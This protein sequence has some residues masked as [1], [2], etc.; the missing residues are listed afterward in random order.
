MAKINSVGHSF[1]D[2]F[3]EML[4]SA[5]K[6]PKGLPSITYPEWDYKK[7]VL[8]KDHCRLYFPKRKDVIEKKIGPVWKDSLR[9]KYFGEISKWEKK[10]AAIVNTENWINRQWS[11]V[12]LDIESYINFRG[13]VNR[14]NFKEMPLYLNQKRA[15]LDT[16]CLLLFDQSF[17]T[18]SWV[19]NKRVLDIELDAIGLTGLLTSEFIEQVAIAGT[20]S[21]TRN[22]CF[23]SLYKDFSQDWSK[24]YQV[25][26]QIEP[27]GYTRLGPAIRHSVE[28]LCAVKARK[29]ILI[30]LTDGKPT[31][32]DRYEGRY[33][34]ED[35]RNALSTAT[36]SG[37]YTKAL[38]IEKSNAAHLAQIFGK[39]R[40]MVLNDVKKFPESLLE[41][42]LSAV[43]K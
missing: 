34:I 23:Y 20:W 10:I 29:R 3:I 32:Y 41:I 43:N 21:E 9:E 22:H 8:K 5:S 33:G 42:L 19:Q 12:E 26:D 11:G 17:S 4:D 30:I 27:Q 7:A 2:G 15:T 6:K 31:D 18:D 37:I 1:I 25:T 35:V 24:F 14:G 40:Y 28:K 39:G 13:D 16:A 38:A 36:A